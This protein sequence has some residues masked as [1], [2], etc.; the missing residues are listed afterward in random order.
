MVYVISSLI[1]R[2]YVS[3]LYFYTFKFKD[4]ALLD[5]PLD[6]CCC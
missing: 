1:V 4:M 2:L 5:V 6:F 3:R